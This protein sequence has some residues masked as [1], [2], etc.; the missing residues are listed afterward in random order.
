MED[1]ATSARVVIAPYAYNSVLLT[2][3]FVVMVWQFIF[4]GY[5]HKIVEEAL[6]TPPYISQFA[7][8]FRQGIYYPRWMPLCFDGY[9]SP[10]FIFYSPLLYMLTGLMHLG[11]LDIPTAVNLLK[12]LSIYAGAISVFFLVREDHNDRASLLS[13]L[14]YILLPS[15]IIEAYMI[16]T[17]AG[18]LGH[19]WLPLT[20]LAARRLVHGPANRANIALMAVSYSGLIL[21]HIATAFIFSPFIAAFGLWGSKLG[22]RLSG[23]LRFALGIVAGLCLSAVLLLPVTLE[24]PLVQINLLETLKYMSDW[25]KPL[26]LAFDIPT[27]INLRH[28]WN[29]VRYCIFV[30]TAFGAILFY[31]IK[32]RAFFKFAD[33]DKIYFWSLIAALFMMSSLSAP[34]W[35]Y[36]PG[37][38][39]INFPARFLSISMLF[40]PILLGIM[41]D[42]LMGIEGRHKIV[43]AVIVSLSLL[44]LA[45]GG[46]LVYRSL[47]PVTASTAE[48]Y[49]G[50]VD[51]IEYLPATTDLQT[52]YGLDGNKPVLSLPDSPRLNSGASTFL[53]SKD[54]FSYA[55]SRWGYVDRKFSIDAPE[56]ALLR[57][58]TFY[59][60]GWRAWLDG[61]NI[62]IGVEDKT[63]AMLIKVPPG[64]HSVELRFTDTW[65]RKAGWIISMLTLTALLFP[66]G[67]IRA[68]REK[69]V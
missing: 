31:I 60:P 45:F 22:E 43:T 6:Y 59:F 37:M 14:F 3:I 41:I 46:L 51:M 23:S 67:R 21:S 61:A 62:P 9:G 48:S 30:E 36:L 2:A 65:P 53:T 32:R 55:I 7:E 57:V 64:K 38:P 12:A 16:N 42:A 50:T 5:Y 4:P 68:L 25:R 35:K 47:P 1:Q 28:I 26:L 24:R 52:L 27:N 56:G 18:R 33:N 15:S 40:M 34:L 19:A 29:L 17:P 66:Y 10:V 39:L 13:A 11:G 8:S 54:K 58:R 63:G 44:V 49:Y 69:G 20:L